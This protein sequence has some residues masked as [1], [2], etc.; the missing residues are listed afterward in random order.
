MDFPYELVISIKPPRVDG[1]HLLSAVRAGAAVG[2][3]AVDRHRPSDRQHGAARPGGHVRDS[4]QRHLSRGRVR[5]ILLGQGGRTGND[6]QGCPP[7]P[8]TDQVGE[9]HRESH[10]LVYVGV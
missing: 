2:G 6:R 8:Y 5:R 10:P 7:P 9:T 4:V 3:R 1:G